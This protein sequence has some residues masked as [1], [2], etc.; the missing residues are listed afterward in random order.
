M[1]IK[2]DL[3]TT[4]M[5]IMPHTDISKA[6]KLALQLDI[7]FWPQLPKVSFYEDMYVQVTENFP[8]ITLD[9]ENLRVELKVEKFYEELMNYA[10]N[11]GNDDYFRLSPKYATV[12]EEFLRQDLSKYELVRGQSIG[13]ISFGLQIKDE[14]KKPV[15]YY[16]EIRQFL[17]EF[18]AKKIQIQY[19]EMKEKHPN[20][21]VW[22][23][24][25]GLEMLFMS[26][27]GYASERAKVD[28]QQFLANI[29]GPKGIHLC[30]NPDWS[31]LLSLDLNILSIDVHQ[32]GHIFS[33]Y[34]QELKDYLNRGG[35]I[36]WGIVPTQTSELSEETILKLE[37]RLENMWEHM[38][39]KGIS[40]EQIISQA[41]LA[42][43]RC[44]LINEDGDKSVEK[45]F[46]LLIKLSE[47]L[48]EKYKI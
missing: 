5:G 1:N 12:Y 29:P 14:N 4:A 32:W 47:K 2:G 16:D 42:P 23:D 46:Q 15:I 48:K 19:E 10:E 6:I 31:F 3:Q 18:M 37:E 36:S 45:A 27:T 22:I 8:G 24:E 41:W 25:P 17:F 26:F 7:P 44:C 39:A 28:L 38:E 9:E 40:K 20:P 33:K 43:A 34:S 11:M 13:P 35:I 21:F 30:G